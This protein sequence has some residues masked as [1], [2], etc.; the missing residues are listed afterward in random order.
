ML[1]TKRLLECIHNKD[2]CISVDLKEAYFHMLVHPRHR[3]F[4]HFAFQGV[5]Y[6]YARMPFRYALTPPIFSKCMEAALEQLRHSRIRLLVYLDDLPV[7][8]PS[9]ELAIAHDTDSD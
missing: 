7:L 5:A 2:F 4:L 1:T 9:A 8:A 3:K 6:E